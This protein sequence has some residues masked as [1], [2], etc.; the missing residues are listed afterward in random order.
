MLPVGTSRERSRTATWV[1]K[2][3]V[4]PSM[5]MAADMR[6]SWRRHPQAPRRPRGGAQATGRFA[7]RKRRPMFVTTPRTQGRRRRLPEVFVVI[8]AGLQPIPGY[9]LTRPLGAGAFGEVWEAADARGRAVAL[10]F[11]DCRTRARGLVS[12]EIKV[13]RG[14]SELRH[15]NIIR[16]HGI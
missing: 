13:L 4:T 7:K 10:K 11:V 8:R 2:V 9:R 3:L 12:G 5:T 14:L 15:P 6:S 1:P 16:L